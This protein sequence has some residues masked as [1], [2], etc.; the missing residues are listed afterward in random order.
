MRAVIY[1]RYSSENQ[2]EAS[3]EDQVRNCW[4]LIEERGWN[5]AKIYGD[6]AISGATNLRPEY[7]RLLAHA[8]D[9]QFEVVVAEGL[10]RL[11]R[12]HEATAG[13]YKLMTF[14]GIAI[15]TRAEGEVTDLH[16]GLKGMMNAIA[17]KDLAIKTRRGIEGRV[18][19]GMSGGGR[20]YGYRIVNQR[21]ANGEPVR[22]LRE[23]D[24]AEADVVRRI[25]SEFAWENPPARSLV[26][27]TPM[28]YQAP[29]A[30]AG[31]IP[32]SEGMQP[33]GLASSE[34]N[35]TP[36][37]CSGTSRPTCAIQT[38]ASDWRVYASRRRTLS[39]RCHTCALLGKIFG[40]ELRLAFWQSGSCRA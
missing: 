10:D 12:D 28:A 23:I 8:R 14:L 2:H 38:R 31:E 26:A 22:G 19:Q 3:I 11:S 30:K 9:H 29:A 33:A 32:P 1:A 27:S 20:A 21:D 40:T 18:R 36:G 13:L 6:R 24:L 15:V 4:R 34:M 25:F 35:S 16:A 37:A 5:L 17:L 39:S 7:Q